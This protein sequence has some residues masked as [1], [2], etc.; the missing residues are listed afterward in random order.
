MRSIVS[1][2][3]GN[4]AAFNIMNA[5]LDSIIKERQETF[6]SDP[7]AQLN[8]LLSQLVKANMQ[9]KILDQDELKSDAYIFTV[10]G[11]FVTNYNM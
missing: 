10:A 4:E 3:T 9:D 2:L 8:D 7:D 5:K 6:S 1:R 11:K